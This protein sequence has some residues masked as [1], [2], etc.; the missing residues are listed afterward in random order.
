M[1]RRTIISEKI[2]TLYKAKKKTKKQRDETRGVTNPSRQI[3]MKRK[4][5]RIDLVFCYK[6]RQS[7]IQ[8]AKYPHIHNPH[9]A[10]TLA[11]SGI[12]RA[13]PETHG[14]YH[15]QQNP[16]HDLF[17]LPSLRPNR[18]PTK[19][20]HARNARLHPLHRLLVHLLLLL[21][22]LPDPLVAIL[23]D[24]LLHQLVLLLAAL[25]HLVLERLALLQA[26]GEAVFHAVEAGAALRFRAQGVAE[27]AHGSAG[28]FGFCLGVF[29]AEFVADL[30]FAP[31][32]FRGDVGAFEGF[33]DFPCVAGVKG[34]DEF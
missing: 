11:M 28:P 14:R 5:L 27:E 34:G 12:H 3:S 26:L 25:P 8:I 29:F 20:K 22:H 2:P 10:P 33:E 19:R 24:L 15:H 7:C 17:P 13:H 30:G 23:A 32:E 1:V 4:T 21:R 31:G 9:H 16:H 6:K 18:S